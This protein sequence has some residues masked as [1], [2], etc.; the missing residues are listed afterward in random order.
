MTLATAVV[1]A[2]RSKRYFLWGI[3]EEGTKKLANDCMRRD[4]LT[5][6]RRRHQPLCSSK[7]GH[8]QGLDLA[9]PTGS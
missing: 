9:L 7:L 4:V 3:L 6:E 8:A 1:T 2:G 5:L